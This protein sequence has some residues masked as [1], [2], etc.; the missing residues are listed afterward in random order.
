MYI[1]QEKVNVYTIGEGTVN[2]Y[3]LGVSIKGSSDC[4][5]KVDLQDWSGS[6]DLQIVGKRWIPKTG[7]DRLFHIQSG[8]DFMQHYNTVCSFNQN[9]NVEQSCIRRLQRMKR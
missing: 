2:V 5:E 1:Q 6:W 9:L 4:R 7:Q 3:T 8:R